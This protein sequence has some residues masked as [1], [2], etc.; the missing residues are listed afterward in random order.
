MG[1]KGGMCCRTGVISRC[2]QVSVVERHEVAGCGEFRAQVMFG[3][4]QCLVAR[5]AREV[6]GEAGSRDRELRVDLELGRSNFL[7]SFGC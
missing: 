6:S 7:Y 3:L 1:L 2:G 4:G 5:L